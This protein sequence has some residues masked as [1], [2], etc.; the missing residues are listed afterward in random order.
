VKTPMDVAPQASG[1]YN[2]DDIIGRV[3]MGRFATPDDVA[4]AI[5]FLANPAESGFVNGHALSVDGGWFA[6]GSW[7]GLRKSKQPRQR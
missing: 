6:D 3:P 4:A 5:A 7:E 2:D 1:L